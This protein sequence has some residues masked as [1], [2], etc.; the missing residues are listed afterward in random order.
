MFEISDLKSKKLP[1]LQE[2][3]DGLK[4]PKY[5]TLKKLDL[6]Y[7]ILDVRLPTQKLFKRRLRKLRQKPKNQLANA[8]QG[9]KNLELL[10]IRTSP[11]EKQKNPT[12]PK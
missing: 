5:K 4:V 2:I 7:Q 12:N 11:M 3:A 1:E 10:L 8:H 6:V 9:L